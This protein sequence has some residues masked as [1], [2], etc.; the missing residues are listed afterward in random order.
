MS[1]NS[2]LWVSSHVGEILYTFFY[3]I[4]KIQLCPFKIILPQNTNYVKIKDS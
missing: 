3:A 2:P 4:I 1:E